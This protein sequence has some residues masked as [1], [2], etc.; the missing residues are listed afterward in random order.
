M[1]VILLV[2][3]WFR[4]WFGFSD[5]EEMIEESTLRLYI[6]MLIQI[7]VTLVHARPMTNHVFIPDPTS[8]SLP[9]WQY[10]RISLSSSPNR[11]GF[12]HQARVQTQKWPV[13]PTNRP[14][15]NGL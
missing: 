6:Y 8:S 14:F 4:G 15:S 13:C 9:D 5:R 2:Y 1:D 11:A 7:A 3:S 10:T 12:Q